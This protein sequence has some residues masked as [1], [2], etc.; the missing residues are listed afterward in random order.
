VNKRQQN[1]GTVRTIF[2]I[3]F[4]G[5]GKSTVGPLL[6]Q[7]LN[8]EF[9]D[10]DTLIEEQTGRTIAQIFAAD[11]EVAFR[12]LETDLI[13]QMAGNVPSVRVIAL[14]GGAFQSPGNRELISASGVTVYLQC[15][16]RELYRRLKSAT[17]RPLLNAR[18]GPVTIETI[19]GLLATRRKAYRMADLTVAT[20][21]RTAAEAA[22]MI[23]TRIRKRYGTHQS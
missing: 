10:T 1:I 15:A 23:E 3:G 7:R 16:V 22:E 20:S 18:S 2:L 17:D 21:S 13:C 14:G 6:A 19:A 11:G 12:S 4:S 8:A 9:I 5:S